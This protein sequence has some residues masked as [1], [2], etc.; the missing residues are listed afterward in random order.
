VGVRH[1]VDDARLGQQPRRRDRQH[2]EH[3]EREQV[4][5]DERA[6]GVPVGR[7]CEQVDRDQHRDGHGHVGDVVVQRQ[8]LPEPEVRR[9]GEIGP[10]LGGHVQGPLEPQQRMS[11][12]LRGDRVDAGEVGDPVVDDEQEEHDGD[13]AVPGRTRPCPVPPRTRHSVESSKTTV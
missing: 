5:R 12:T 6:A 4:H 8:R 3:G 10:M 9:H 2:D 13:L 11:P 7:R 1:D